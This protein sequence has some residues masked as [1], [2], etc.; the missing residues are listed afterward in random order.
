[1][2]YQVPA[3]DVVPVLRH[4]VLDTGTVIDMKTAKVIYSVARTTVRTISPLAARTGTIPL[5]V[6]FVS[7]FM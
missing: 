5:I 1:M 3:G 7:I 2:E 4:A 6:A